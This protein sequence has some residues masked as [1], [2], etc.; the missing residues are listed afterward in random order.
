MKALCFLL[1]IWIILCSGTPCADGHVHDESGK[2]TMAYIHIP[3]TEQ[4]AG[5]DLCSPFCSCYCCAVT[6]TIPVTTVF[7]SRPM[8]LAEIPDM[9]ICP[10]AADFTAIPWQPPRFS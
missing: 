7:F 6:I 2:E 4:E 5:V 10:P 1:S 9:Y 8:P 3:I